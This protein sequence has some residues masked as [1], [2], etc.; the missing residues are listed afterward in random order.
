MCA[1]TP[2][3]TSDPLSVPF[4]SLV[5]C[6]TCDPCIPW[7]DRPLLSRVNTSHPAR[8]ILLFPPLNFLVTGAWE[9]MPLFFSNMAPHG[10]F[11]QTGHGFDLW[12]RSLCF[13]S[14]IFVGSNLTGFVLCQCL[15]CFFVLP[16]LKVKILSASTPFSSLSFVGSWFFVVLPPAAQ[17][18][19][20]NGLSFFD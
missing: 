20:P 11:F 14:Y 17:P 2:G 9:G 19:L 1:A 12:G 3:E 5:G 4:F 13:P 7:F 8:R 6:E 18:N 10:G 16:P 15:L